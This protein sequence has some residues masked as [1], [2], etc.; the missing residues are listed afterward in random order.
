M[1]YQVRKLLHH[2]G[3]RRRHFLRTVVQILT[4]RS[5]LPRPPRVPPSYIHSLVMRSQLSFLVLL[6]SG[7]ILYA[8]EHLGSMYSNTI[9]E[10]IERDLS[11]R[12]LIWAHLLEGRREPEMSSSQLFLRSHTATRNTHQEQERLRERYWGE[13]ERYPSSRATQ[14]ESDDGQHHRKVM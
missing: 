14:T 11:V 6:R 1:Q 2:R 5:A 13:G 10:F 4:L 12:S 9:P 7:P 3:R 8:L